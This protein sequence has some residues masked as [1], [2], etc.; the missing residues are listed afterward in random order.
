MCL[1]RRHLAESLTDPEWHGEPWT[2]PGGGIAEMEAMPQIT[3]V[4]FASLVADCLESG[5]LSSTV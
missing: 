5:L 2:A 4:L 1:C 3:R